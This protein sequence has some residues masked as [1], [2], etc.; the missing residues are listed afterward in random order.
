MNTE[1]MNDAVNL[2]VPVPQSISAADKTPWIVVQYVPNAGTGG[3]A[4]TCTVAGTTM[5]FTVDGSTPA[6]ADVIGVS[7]VI[8][9]DSSTY[10]TLGELVDYIDGRQAWRAYLV[11]GLRADKTSNLLA[12][13]STS[14]IGTNGY[15]IY[16]DT[17][18]S[19]EI[20]IAVSGEK[21]TGT[22]RNQHET[23]WDDQCI[24]RMNYGAFTLGDGT[25]TVTLT[26]YS[27]KKGS[28]EETLASFTLTED[29]LKELGEE[30]GT[31]PYIQSKPGE[32]LI[33]RASTDSAFDA[34]TKFQVLGSTAVLSGR[35]M[36][37]EDN[38]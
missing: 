26:I 36:I 11:A 13:A 27:G 6:G 29:T 24:N 15:T 10:D 32:R 23:D 28:T 2:A 30:N 31:L 19:K 22:G 3:T 9:S 7:G 18:N 21:F 17:S 5:T 37:T 38:Y 16:S 34:Y 20:G 1:K 4:A 12:A 8:D 33:V 14:C 25:G 35:R